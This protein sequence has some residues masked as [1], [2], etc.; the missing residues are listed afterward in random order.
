MAAALVGGAFLSAS[1]QTLMDKLTSPEFRDYFTRTELNESLMYEMETSLLTLEVVLDDAEEKQILKPRIKQ[2][3]DRLKDAIYDAEDLLN[4]ISY[5]ALRCKL[6]KKQAINSEME[7]IT[8]QFRNLLST[9]NS[10]EEINSEMQKICKRLQ[11][12]VQQSTAIGLQHTVSG[13]V[14]HRLPSSSV[15]NESVMVGR[16]D[17]K[18]TIMNMLLSQRETT[19][20]NIGVVAILGMGGLGKTT[21]AQ[22]VY[23]DKEVQQHFDMKA[24]ACVSED[25]DIMR[26]TKSL[27]ESVTSRNWDI[28]N[29][30]ILRVELKKISREKRFL[31]VLDDLWNDNYNDWGELVSPFVDGK[32]GS[33]VIITTRQQK[34]AEVACT[35]PIHELKLLS[36]EDCWSLLSKHALGSDEIQHNTNT[37]LEETGRKIARKCGGLPIA[38]K[39]LGGLLRSKVDITEWTSILNSDIWNLSND[40]ILPALHLSYQYL[41]SHLKRCFAYCSIFPKDYPLERKTLVLLWMAEGFLDCSQGGKKLEELGDDCFAELLSRSLIQQLS[42]D[43]RGEKFVMHDLVSDL[44]TVVSGKSCCRLECGD[45]TENVRHFSYN[46][47]YYDI[48]MKFEKLHNF[49]C[50]RSFISFSSMTW[51]YSYLSFKV[52]NDL[53]PSQK[54]LRVLSLSRYKNIIKLPDSIGNLVQ[55]RYLDISFTKIKSLP[56]TTCSLY[57]L[58][59]LNLSRCDSLTELPIH[60]GNLVGLRHLDISGT[61]INE[62]PVEIGG[63][64]NLQ[65]L[66]LFLVGKRHI[67]LSIKELRK[68]PNLQGKLTIKNLDN[69]VDAREA[70]DA[71]LKSKEKIEELEL[72][73]GKQSEESQK[74]KVVLDMLQPPINL[75]SLKI[76][77]YGG[78]SFPSWLGNSSFYNMVSLRITNCEYCMTLPPIGQLPSLKDLEIC[79]M[80]RLETIGPEFYYVQGEEGSCSSF[81]PFQSLERIKFNSLPNWNEWLPYEGIKLSFPRLRAMELHNCPELREHLPSKLPCIEEI[82]IKGCS[83]LLETEPNTLHWLSSVKKINI[84]GLD[85]RTQLSLLESDSPCM[86]QEVVIRECVKLL[87][88]PKLILRSTCLTHLKLSSLPSLTTFPSSGLP[89]SL[90]S[91]EIVNCENLSF[92]PPETWSNYTS[93]VSLELNRSCDS[94]TSFPLDGFPALQTLDIY[95]CR[96]L[97][98]IYILERS[99]PRSSSLESLTIKSHDS[100]ELFEVKLKMEML[101]ALER[102]FLT[103]A[104]LSFSE[105]VCLPPKLQSI[106]ISTQKTTPPVTEWGLQYLTALSYLTIQKGDDIFNTLMKESLL[107]ISLLYLRVFDLSEMKSFDG[108]GLQH[109]SSLQYLCFFF[110]HQLETLPENCLPSSLKSLLLLGCEKLESLPE[111]SLPSSLK[112]LAIEFCPL[113]EE[114]YK[115]K[116]H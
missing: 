63:L 25:F 74:V 45:I 55:L 98:S 48:F 36:N 52:V 82:V 13:R 17:D 88:V 49:K 15:V 80:K 8:D 32:P 67:G 6:E 68:F 97:D 9:S 77:L 107:P 57:N 10:N 104:E 50:L 61:N 20:N 26:V 94:L 24:W 46:Q 69:V 106:E 31:F 2:W 38:A 108:N 111:D 41:P 85:G 93:L 83:H 86:M 58:Q 37:A 114:R 33:M 70:H 40:N 92:L 53:L 115:R 28:N 116:E 29:L 4:K 7:K 16:K 35:F 1:V 96:S 44:A 65:T 110:C 73:W 54:R 79:G 95:K 109:L 105:G 42:D 99:S 90:Q 59:T 113:L 66:T 3:L 89:T 12:F 102:L 56:D 81:Q 18:E 112:L 30:D 100:I 22:L 11:T 39:T 103:C 23:N 60:I 72:I 78:T 91:L 101:T 71:N 43:A 75:K 51:N 5:N 19:N 47:E 27:L 62:L 34:V 21:L 14:S 84:D 87:A 76:C 64:E